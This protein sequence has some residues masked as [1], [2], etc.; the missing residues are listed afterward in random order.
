MKGTSKITIVT[1]LR[2][3]HV[4]NRL[5]SWLENLHV[6]AATPSFDVDV[7]H[8]LLAFVAPYIVT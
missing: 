4:A 1:P 8:R 5:C 3:S 2:A 7:S 6:L